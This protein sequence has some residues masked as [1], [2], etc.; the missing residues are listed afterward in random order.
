[1]NFRQIKYFVATAETGQV[2]RAANALSI[3]QSAVT[4]AI[5]ELEAQIGT[6]LFTRTAHGMEMTQSGRGLLALSYE[7]LTKIDEAVKLGFT[8]ADMGGEPYWDVCYAHMDAHEQKK[9]GPRGSRPDSVVLEKV[10]L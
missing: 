1:M 10:G 5:R 6:E 8:F 2:S 9:G 7:I 3:S 4:T